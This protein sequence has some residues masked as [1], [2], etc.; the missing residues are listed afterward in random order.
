MLTVAQGPPR[1]P[2]ISPLTNRIPPAILPYMLRILGVV[3]VTC[4]WNT[5][6]FGLSTQVHPSRARFRASLMPT[7]V[8]IPVE[9][10]AWVQPVMGARRS[11]GEFVRTCLWNHC[12]DLLR[13]TLRQTPLLC[14][15]DKS[16]QGALEYG[17]L[18]FGIDTEIKFSL[19]QRR[20]RGG[21]G[22]L[23]FF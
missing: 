2:A 13:D 10:N 8:R 22:G 18:R 16:Q 3:G 4:F 11:I 21:R 6:K 20:R 12:H 5:T 15:T 9:P 1:T 19:V 7:V 14:E 23:L 17:W